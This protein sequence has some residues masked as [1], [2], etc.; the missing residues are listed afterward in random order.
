MPPSRAVPAPPSATGAAPSG[1]LRAGLA[2]ALAVAG[3]VLAVWG[4][5]RP[6]LAADFVN[7]D[8][9]VTVLG[10]GDRLGF[11]PEQLRWMATSF[12][13]GHWHPL[14]W[15]SYALD[16]VLWGDGPFGFHL[17]NVVLHALGAALFLFVAREIL[18]AAE[19]RREAK[20][21]REAAE[22]GALGPGRLR[23]AA[24]V[25]AVAF[26]LHPLRVESVAWVSERRDVLSGA[27]FLAALLAWLL[28]RRAPAGSRRARWLFA[29]FVAALVASL[30][31]KAWA[32]ALPVVLV[33]LESWPGAARPLRED[34]PR[35]RWLLASLAVSVPLSLATLAIAAAAQQD[36]GATRDWAGHGLVERLAQSAYGLAF[37]PLKT[38]WPAQL[39]ALYPLGP[40]LDPLAPRF[41]VPALAIVAVA[42]LAWTQRRSRPWWGVALLAYAAIVA[43][44]LGLL[45]SGPQLVADRYSYLATLPF[46]LLAGGG[47]LALA[48]VADR[49]EPRRGGALLAALVAALALPL[50]AATH[51]RCGAW[52]DS[53]AL[54]SAAVE[55]EPD[56]YF[57]RYDLGKALMDAGRDAEAVPQLEQ[58]LARE[59]GD[60]A[61]RVAIR[62]ALGAALGNLGRLG[63]AEAHWRAALALDPDSVPVLADL[64]VAAR[65]AGDATG[66][67]AWAARA[68]AAADRAVAAGRA[69]DPGTEAAVLRARAVLEASG[70]GPDGGAGGKGADG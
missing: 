7:L 55:V 28:G 26:A 31:S 59:P 47:A 3:L 10:V 57:V 70:P 15:A 36:W 12:R 6:A 63:E 61:G 68:L 24:L 33:A 60:V 37:Y 27:W 52:H 5:F 19:L 2:D 43:P 42:G 1:R 40:G 67:G 44:V 62:Q 34:A 50:G 46:A 64:A 11:A 23:L 49:R 29:A 54:W 9:D 22:G 25:A 20:R 35:R 69:P 56:S 66:A 30:L 39:S 21:Q 14:T 45:Q 18:R 48:R 53:V 17:T 13:A 8:D 4:A 58:A 38:L 51:A 32:A 41:L 16:R 65:L